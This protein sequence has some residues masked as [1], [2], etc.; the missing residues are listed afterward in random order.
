MVE[1]LSS[2]SSFKSSGPFSDCCRTS[3][4]TGLPLIVCTS[5]LGTPFTTGRFG[6]RV[7]RLLGPP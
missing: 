6:A 7:P 2:G 1:Q 5:A 3:E 4:V